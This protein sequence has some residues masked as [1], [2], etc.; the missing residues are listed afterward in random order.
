MADVIQFHCPAC[1]IALSVPLDAAGQHGPCPHCHQLIIAPDP[2]TGASACRVAVIEAPVPARAPAPPAFEPFHGVPAALPE[3]VVSE[4]RRTETTQ[5]ASAWPAALAI[6]VVAAI[7]GFAGG[8]QSARFLPAPAPIVKSPIVQAPQAIVPEKSSAAPALLVPKALLDDFLAAPDWKSRSR[9]VLMEQEVTPRMETYHAKHPD[10]P[11]KATRTTIEHCE[12]DPVSNLMLVVFRIQTVE[13]P[14]GFTVAVAETPD[15]WKID[16]ESFVEFKDE[17]FIEF[18]AGKSG[19][20]GKFHLV[21]L[22]STSPAQAEDKVS[23]ILSDPVRGREF[24]A[25]IQKGTDTEKT[26]ESLT[27]DRVAAT[28]VLELARQS[29]ADGSYELNIVGVPATNWRPKVTP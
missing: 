14:T 6:G 17:L 16:W 2:Y 13:C 12:A 4:P 3:P 29:R 7:L 19:E 24:L 25:N 23:Y 10:G 21:L 5:Q 20:T 26:L 18:V 1:C 22:P 15:G 8:Y 28:P 11:T 9:F 27:K